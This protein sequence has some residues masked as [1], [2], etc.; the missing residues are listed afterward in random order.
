MLG[1][2]PTATHAKDNPIGVDPT[3]PVEIDGA[4]NLISRDDAKSLLRTQRQVYDNNVRVQIGNNAPPKFPTFVREGYDMT[5]VADEYQQAPS[6]L[7]Y[8]DD[9]VGD[10]PT[11]EVG[12]FT[13]LESSLTHEPTP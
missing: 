6:G 1:F 3:A 4:I 8:V 9:V 13:K 12:E 11:P 7:F 10:G 5:I 2:T